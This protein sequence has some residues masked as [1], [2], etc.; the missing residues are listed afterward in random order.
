MNNSD[1]IKQWLSPS[2]NQK[3]VGRHESLSASPDTVYSYQTAIARY[4]NNTV[5]LN[6]VN[7][8]VTTSKH[9]S[10]VVAIAKQ[11]DKPVVRVFTLDGGDAAIFRAY[12]Y[13]VDRDLEKLEKARKPEIYHACIANEVRSAQHYAA[14]V[15]AD[16]PDSLQSKGN[17]SIL[18]LKLKGLN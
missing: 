1:F 9:Q 13:H 3:S 16:M 11:L 12:E 4:I 7:Y 18:F 17:K 10:L 2:E 8:S 15:G 6:I 14:A 5:I